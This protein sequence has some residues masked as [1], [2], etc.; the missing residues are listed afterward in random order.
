MGRPSDR[1]IGLQII[2]F[3][4]IF[5]LTSSVVVVASSIVKSVIYLRDRSKF[6]GYL[7][8]VLG[9][10][11][12]KNR[13]GNLITPLLSC[14]FP[15]ILCHQG[16]LR[17]HI[18]QVDGQRRGDGRLRVTEVPGYG[19]PW[20]IGPDTGGLVQHRN[21]PVHGGLRR[22]ETDRTSRVRPVQKAVGESDEMAVLLRPEHPQRAR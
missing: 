19:V 6:I 18:L 7:G 1:A 9:N 4:Y 16:R 20:K 14:Q 21:L 3:F 17:L 13:V 15:M 11:L 22:P 10:L 5:F 8:Q 2:L 12:G